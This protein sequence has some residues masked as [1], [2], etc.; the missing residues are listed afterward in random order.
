MDIWA[1]GCVF[2]EL[3]AKVEGSSEKYK[4]L[5]VSDSSYPLSPADESVEYVNGFRISNEDLMG[6]IISLLGPP[7]KEDQ[8]FISDDTALNFITCFKKEPGRS[9]E[10]LFPTCGNDARD[11]LK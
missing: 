2:G 11:L 9:F 7:T 5:F 8:S 4:A 3:L 6:R 10:K 1:I